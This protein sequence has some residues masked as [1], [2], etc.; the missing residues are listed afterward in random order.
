M[1]VEQNGILDRGNRDYQQ[2]R[3]EEREKVRMI[4]VKGAGWSMGS[5]KKK[6][7]IMVN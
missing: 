7:R 4:R 1:N 3:S 2:P 6:E 5:E